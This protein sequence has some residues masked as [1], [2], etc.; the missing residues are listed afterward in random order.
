MFIA[1]LVWCYAVVFRRAAREPGG[2]VVAPLRVASYLVGVLIL[3]LASDWPIGT[4]GSGY[5]LSVHTLQYALYCLVAPP[6]LLLGIPPSLILRIESA[7]P[8]LWRIMRLAANPLLALLVFNVVLLGSHSQP[9]VDGIRPSQLGSFAVDM[10]WLGGGLVLWWPVIAP[11]PQVS[12]LS[13]PARFGYLFLATILPIIP[14]AFFVFADYP[15]YALYEL[16]PRVN[17]IP[18]I[19]D[20]LV[21][22]IAMTV[23]GN[24]VMWTA[25]LVV[26]IRWVKSEAEWETAQRS[27]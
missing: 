25:M 10:A 18:A 15:L 1:L 4:L 16:A 23:L 26:A 5:L 22:G 13:Y 19:K 14:A 3:W 20:Q 12:R 11:C 17:G 6:L 7:A 2:E 8:L 21:A 9:V 24:A 27:H